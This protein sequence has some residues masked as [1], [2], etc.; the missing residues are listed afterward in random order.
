MSSDAQSGQDAPPARASA[1]CD[2]DSVQYKKG[3]TPGELVHGGSP[4]TFR[5][6]LPP[7]Y[8]GVKPLPLLL[9]L[10]GGGGGGRQFEVSARMD[11]VADRE[12]FAVVY[13]DGSGLLKTWN[14]GGC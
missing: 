4:R 6:H 2:S 12:S 10:H 5:V 1:G 14:G 8:D 3:T 13:P 7:N 9:M 11:P